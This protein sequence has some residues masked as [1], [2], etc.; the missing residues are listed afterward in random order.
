MLDEDGLAIALTRIPIVSSNGSLYRCVDL[1]YLSAPY[2]PPRPLYSLGAP[3][4]GARF[5]PLGGPPSLY[6]AEDHATALAEATLTIATASSMPPKVVFSAK[7]SL[8]VILDLTQN[9]VQQMLETSL[10]ELSGSW[11]LS[12]PTGPLP[13]TQL[14][15]KAVFDSGRYSAIRYPSTKRPG[16]NCLVIF[17]GRLKPP[18]F[19]EVYDPDGNLKGRIP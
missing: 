18:S 19:V 16:G 11:R 8:D 5:T 9:Y 10:R 6:M 1:K 7:A 17:T 4:T 13:P 14:L 12:N 15:G 3:A 2:S